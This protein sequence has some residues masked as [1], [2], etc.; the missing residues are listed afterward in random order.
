[1]PD[2]SWFHLFGQIFL[3]GVGMKDIYVHTLRYHYSGRGKRASKTMFPI[4]YGPFRDEDAAWEWVRQSGITRATKLMTIPAEENV[5][6]PY[7]HLHIKKDREIG[8]FLQ[9]PTHQNSIL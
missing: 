3:G 8:S 7:S 2:S 6:V 1:M 9:I 4:S 5:K